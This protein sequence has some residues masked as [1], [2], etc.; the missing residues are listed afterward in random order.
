[1]ATGDFFSCALKTD[2]TVW[3]WGEPW[4]GGIGNGTNNKSVAPAQVMTGS[5]TYLTGVTSVDLGSQHACA[6]K[7]DG[8]LWCWGYN[9]V[10]QVGTGKIKSTTITYATQVGTAKTWAK[11]SATSNQ[12]CGLMT[13]GSLWCWGQNA[14]SS[15]PSPTQ[16]GTATD[17]ADVKTGISHVCARK[18][19]G[20]MWCWGD[21]TYGQLG[22]G[23]TTNA[24]APTQVTGVGTSVVA[25]AAGGAHSCAARSDGTLW[26]WGQNGSKEVGDGTTV[27]RSSPVQVTTFDTAVLV[28]DMA[29]GQHHTCALMADGSIRCWGDNGNGQLGS[30]AWS[31]SMPSQQVANNVVQVSA[32]DQNSCL[33]KSD[34]TAWCWGNNAYGAL[35][36][37]STLPSDHPVQ[38]L[39]SAGT[40][41]TG[42]A[43]VRAGGGHTCAR[44]TD[45]SVWCWGL[46]AL[47]QVGNATT[48][49]APYPVSVLTGAAKVTVGYDI[50]CALKTDGTV[51]CWGDNNF[52]G[53][54]QGT[55]SGITSIPKQ[56]TGLSSVVDLTAG[57]WSTPCAVTSTGALYCWG[58]NGTGEVGNGTTA[59]ALNPVLV[60][61]SGVS[62]VVGGDQT[63]CALKTNGTIW[64]WGFNSAGQVGNG[65]S[66]NNVLT[67]VQATV[68]GAGFTGV[69]TGGE[70]ACGVK[71]DNSLWCW[72]Q[73]D[74]GQL[75]NG[76]QT[77]VVGNIQ[78]STLTNVSSVSVGEY[79]TYAIKSDGTLWSWGDNAAGEAG[80]GTSPTTSV[81]K[82][83][84]TW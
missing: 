9:N 68:A 67:P 50:S 59:K 26:C 18:S 27:Q 44:K 28:S 62:R 71:S 20:S 47:G 30:G 35:G 78:Y 55:T 4:Y 42:V 75:G 65:T 51:W 45:G 11:V 39:A 81:P 3:C 57:L 17:W 74:N 23:S 14:V 43:E 82:R 84:V 36:N 34:G 6:V 1:V 7:T 19:S 64:C 33:A 83:A 48:V 46:N 77:T 16:V 31:Y 15:N 58:E 52:G 73:N 40:P 8:S 38:V 5:S 70:Y 76:I 41:L 61:S 21:N 72:G 25:I 12:T 24:S 56:V 10:G 60:L 79:T 80:N 63:T 37:G 22:I 53:T 54:G 2:G 32:N 49:S 66:G 29:A 69:A 13:T